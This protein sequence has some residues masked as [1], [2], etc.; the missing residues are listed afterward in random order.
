MHAEL[1]QLARELVAGGRDAQGGPSFAQHSVLSFV[2]RNPGCRATDISDAF[3]VNRSTVSRQLRGC[4]DGGWVRADS[5]P[6]RSG[7]PLYLTVQGVAVL[8]AADRRRF[9]DVRA[10][11]DGWSPT[12]IAQF[13]QILRRFRD[14]P[15][16]A[17][18]VPEVPETSAIPVI[19]GVPGV[20]A[21]AGDDA[22]A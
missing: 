9:D 14:G 10:R 16:A 13:A 3:G 11:V 22:H 17:L 4:T 6:V 20:P 12:E 19:P 1:V 2:A 18:E 7:R 5:A 8:A 15:L 21:T